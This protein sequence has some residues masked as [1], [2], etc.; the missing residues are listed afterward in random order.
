MPIMRTMV[1]VREALVALGAGRAVADGTWVARA[2]GAVVAAAVGV[3]VALT[4]ELAAS[5]AMADCGFCAN[6]AVTM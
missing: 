5:G 1:G 2:V 3:S 6:I 4:C